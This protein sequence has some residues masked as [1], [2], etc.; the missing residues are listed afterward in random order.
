M[1]HA[2]NL[3][4]EK[5]TVYVGRAGRGQHGMFGNPFVVGRDGERGECVRKFAAWFYSSDPDATYM[6]D[7]VRTHIKPT[8]VLGCF[9]KP[10]S[11]HGDIIAAYVNAGYREPPSIPDPNESSVH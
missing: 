1:A 11:C 7:M 5:Y 10:A 3:R 9:C 8:D 6:R 2:V 4:N